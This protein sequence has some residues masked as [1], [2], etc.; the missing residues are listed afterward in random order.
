MKLFAKRLRKDTRGFSIVEM[1]IAVGILAAVSTV[2]GS[3]M[4]FSAQSYKT[5]STEASLQQDSH[6]TANVIESLLVDATNTVNFDGSSKTLE[7]NNVDAKHVIVLNAANELVYTCTDLVSGTSTSSVLAKNVTDFFVDASDFAKSRNAQIKIGMEKDGRPIST[8]YNVTSRNDPKSST[9]VTVSKTVDINVISNVTLEPNQEYSFPVNVVASGG[10]SAEYDINITNAD[11]FNTRYERTTDG[12]KVIV[13]NNEKGGAAGEFYVTLTTQEVNP[14]TGN[15]FDSETVTVKVRRVLE[16]SVGPGVLTNGTALKTNAEYDLPAAV[17]GTNLTQVLAADYDLDYKDTSGVTWSVE[18]SDGSPWTDYIEITNKEE[19]INPILS[20]KLKQDLLPGIKIKFTAS[21]KHSRG[22]VNYVQTN[23]AGIQYEEVTK[24]WELGGRNFSQNSDFLRGDD[25]VEIIEH[26]DWGA[27]K[28]QYG[29]NKVRRSIRFAPAKLD[30][31]GNILAY[32]G[33]WTEWDVLGD[34]STPGFTPVRP[35]EYDL[36]PCL[37]Y[38]VEIMYEYVDD[39][40]NVHWPTS[41]T[42]KEEYLFEFTIPEVRLEFLQYYDHNG[43]LVMFPVGTFGI[44]QNE[45]LQFKRDNLYVIDVEATAGHLDKLFVQNSHMKYELQRYD[46]SGTT[47]Q[48]VDVSTEWGLG[49][50]GNKTD[51]WMKVKA[52]GTEGMYKL[53]LKWDETWMSNTYSDT[54]TFAD[55]T[56]GNGIIYFNVSN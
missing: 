53:T 45:A 9:A 34:T 48:W 47:P 50:T 22:V 26:I 3:A 25:F 11:D 12:V 42:A 18:M 41:T 15:P 54:S 1:L 52:P 21:S 56:T 46:T 37:A 30:A 44:P 20:F 31:D 19:D 35:D 14:L 8:V 7:I 4:V 39:A 32:L 55:E 23:K 17:L 5:G 2:I 6:F 49:Y 38:A 16:L 36:N 40:G 33:S 10:A 29:G 27:I 43:Q 28:D 51:G 13:G 24:S